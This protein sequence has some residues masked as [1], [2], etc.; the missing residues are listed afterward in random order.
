M[1]RESKAYRASV[2]LSK[3][4]SAQFSLRDKPSSDKESDLSTETDVNTR[5]SDKSKK[6]LPDKRSQCVI[7]PHMRG[8]L[9][10]FRR[11]DDV[12]V[13]A[14]A[15]FLKSETDLKNEVILEITSIVSDPSVNNKTCARRVRR[16]L[17]DKDEDDTMATIRYATTYFIMNTID[18]V[19]SR[20]P[21]TENVLKSE[22]VN[23]PK[24]LALPHGAH[25]MGK[26]TSRT[27][28][29]SKVS[30]SIALREAR[31]SRANLRD[32]PGP[33][34]PL[35]LK[36]GDAKDKKKRLIILGNLEAAATEECLETIM[37]EPRKAT[38]SVVDNALKLNAESIEVAE[39]VFLLKTLADMPLSEILE[40]DRKWEAELKRHE[41]EE[42]ELKNKR[43]RRKSDMGFLGRRK[44]MIKKS[45]SSSKT[46]I[47][48][49]G[50]IGSV[51]SESSDKLAEKSSVSSSPFETES[52]RKAAEKKTVI[53]Q[54]PT[55]LEQDDHSS[56]DSSEDSSDDKSLGEGSLTAGGLS[57][58]LSPRRPLSP[59]ASCPPSPKGSRSRSA[60]RQVAS[61]GDKNRDRSR[62]RSKERMRDRSRERSRDRL[63]TASSRS[64]RSLA[65]EKHRKSMSQME[66]EDTLG[67][68]VQ[69]MMLL[70]H[71]GKLKKPISFS[72]MPPTPVALDQGPEVKKYLEAK[73]IHDIFESLL[74]SLLVDLP[75][76]PL[77]YLID[78]TG[79]M[80]RLGQIEREIDSK[81]DSWSHIGSKSSS[82]G[83]SGGNNGKT[84]TCDIGSSYI[85][86]DGGFGKN[87]PPVDA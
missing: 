45:F 48:A 72:D 17:A 86:L 27:T 80:N 82:V 59:A 6:Q 20:G 47:A 35:L 64:G 38:D 71:E 51:S 83:I 14:I 79:R 61:F 68:E 18:P 49:R 50:R 1:A 21:I 34:I 31:T 36:H 74:V 65:D 75:S 42:G 76:Q 62:E 40:T 33:G 43:G 70:E 25:G 56:E 46:N 9:S 7:S 44:S 77:D 67:G 39:G 26:R 55:P 60:V 78:L 16:I 69:S 2:I 54:E 37:V 85:S 30:S 3:I 53:V 4:I 23:P 11:T 5:D 19:T 84:S 22:T 15:Y 24:P 58:S 73:G 57:V 81:V 87:L 66:V 13:A 8:F 52:Q 28:N 32:I 12:C 41:E 10:V 63:R 29:T